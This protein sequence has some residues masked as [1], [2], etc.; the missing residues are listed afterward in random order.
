MREQRPTFN[1]ELEP[2][3]VNAQSLSNRLQFSLRS[4]FEG[5][6]RGLA[7]DVD[8]RPTTGS[9]PEWRVNVPPGL[10]KLYGAI[11]GLVNQADMFCREFVAL[12]TMEPREFI[13]SVWCLVDKEE[14]IKGSFD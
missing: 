8:E 14:S 7:V 1:D 11:S 2:V 5:E 12:G 10:P 3:K 6:L 9:L 13:V 4:I